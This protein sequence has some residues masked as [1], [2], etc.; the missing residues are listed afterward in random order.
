MKNSLSLFDRRKIIEGKPGR[1]LDHAWN[2]Q[3]FVKRV[4]ERTGIKSF[5]E[6]K[7]IIQE[8]EGNRK[9]HR[10][11]TQSQNLKKSGSK[12]TKFGRFVYHLYLYLC[13]EYKSML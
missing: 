11:F 8:T 3:R 9:K 7:R 12:Q 2:Q 10:W 1:R 5:T 4:M 6:F 13:I